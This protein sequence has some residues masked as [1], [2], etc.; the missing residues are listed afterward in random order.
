[1]NTRTMPAQ[2]QSAGFRVHKYDRNS[3]E[4]GDILWRGAGKGKYGHT[5]IYL[6]NG[7]IIGAHNS[8]KGIGERSLY[9]D[10]THVF[11]LG[12]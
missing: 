2:L 4:I 5:E 11:R 12:R 9:D 1:M 8:R 7:R 10:F 6:G 3:L